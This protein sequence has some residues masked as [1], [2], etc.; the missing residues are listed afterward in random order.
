[1]NDI[2][3][4]RWGSLADLTAGLTEGRRAAHGACMH[5]RSTLPCDMS[6]GACCMPPRRPETLQP[7]QLPALICEPPPHVG[8][9]LQ[10]HLTPRPLQAMLTCMLPATAALPTPTL[11][12]GR[13]R[14]GACERVARDARARGEGRQATAISLLPT[15]R[16]R[17]VGGGMGGRPRF[18]A[19][20]GWQVVAHQA[21][22]IA[23][24]PGVLGFRTAGP[25]LLPCSPCP[26]VPAFASVF[27]LKLTTGC[28]RRRAEMRSGRSQMQRPKEAASLS[29]RRGGDRER[30]RAGE[31]REERRDD[32]R[33]GDRGRDGGADRERGGSGSGQRGSWRDRP[34]RDPLGRRGDSDVLKAAAAELNQFEGDG[35]FLEQFQ[36]L[37]AEQGGQQAQQGDEE[38]RPTAGA[39]VQPSASSDSEGEEEQR[40]RGAAQQGQ[41]QSMAAAMAAER[42]SLGARPPAPAAEP[43]PGGRGGGAEQP[44]PG[45]DGG[46]NTQKRPAG[47]LSAAAMLRARLTGKAPPAEA[48]PPAQSATAAAAAAPAG[49]EEGGLCCRYV[50]CTLSVVVC[51][52]FASSSSGAPLVS[53]VLPRAHCAACRRAA[54]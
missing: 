17:W 1:M 45:S 34:P 43:S 40:Q 53:P 32:R 42:A 20:R 16:V 38:A 36:R 26:V 50:A 30:R 23:P 8:V 46:G 27:R 12:G 22:G 48:G 15:C 33:D 39:E 14:G 6:A 29:W 52:P 10:T 9:V 49:P 41:Q 11:T 44:L 18:R 51:V 28:A 2:V 31:G 25:H 21:V 35:S 24:C 7:R 5:H 4:E 19:G 37:Q 54:P 13:R 3:S 47:N